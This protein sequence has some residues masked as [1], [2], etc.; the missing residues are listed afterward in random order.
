MVELSDDAAGQPALE[1]QPPFDDLVL[2]VLGRLAQPGILELKQV[3]DDV[4]A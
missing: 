1:L 2:P 4:F 3:L